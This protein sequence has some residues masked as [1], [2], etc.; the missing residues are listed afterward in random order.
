MDDSDDDTDDDT[1][2]LF[3]AGFLISLDL[4]F[5]MMTVLNDFL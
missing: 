5:G 3:D 2:D 4:G 1:D